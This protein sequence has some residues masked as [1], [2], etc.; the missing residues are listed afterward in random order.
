MLRL[1]EGTENPTEKV[2]DLD[3]Y[4]LNVYEPVWFNINPQIALQ[5][6]KF[7]TFFP[8]H[9][10]KKEHRYMFLNIKL[11]IKIKILR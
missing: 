7:V 4:I 1:Y 10:Y 11:K 8:L 9:F 3:E 2:K 5:K 6:G